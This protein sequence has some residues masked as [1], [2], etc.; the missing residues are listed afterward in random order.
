MKIVHTGVQ[1][2]S[3]TTLQESKK[4]KSANVIYGSAESKYPPSSNFTLY[5][6]WAVKWADHA[7]FLL[8]SLHWS[9]NYLNTISLKFHLIWEV[10]GPRQFLV[11]EFISIPELYIQNFVVLH[12]FVEEISAEK[13]ETDTLCF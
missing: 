4:K 6:S 8:P 3:P 10:G 11:S 7:H 9:L 1:T 12:A 13:Y 2:K 5:G